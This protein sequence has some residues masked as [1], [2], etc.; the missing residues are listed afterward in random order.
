VGRT[1]TAQHPFYMAVMEQFE[2]VIRRIND[3]AVPAE[4]PLDTLIPEAGTAQLETSIL[5]ANALPL[6]DRYCFSGA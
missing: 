2:P 4:S 6:A 5:H 1:E 3:Y